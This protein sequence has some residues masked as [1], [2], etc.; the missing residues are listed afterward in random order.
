MAELPP[1]KLD[2]ARFE[3]HVETLPEAQWGPAGMDA[4]QF[5]VATNPGAAA[6][7]IDKIASGGELSRFMLAI[8]V[9]LAA[10]SSVPVLV[11]DEVDAGIG[12]ATADAVGERLARLAQSGRQ[13]LVV[14]HS[15][16]VAARAG[17][18]WIVAK[19][20]NDGSMRTTLMRLKDQ[21]NRTEE[22]AR[23]IS[24]AKV[25]PEALAAAGKL[26]QQAS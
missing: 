12:G 23:M 2:K 20:A 14:T 1:L 7:P 24:G 10:T 5:V 11:F 13:V 4:V 17:H 26:L 19:A 6:G 18:H 3:T 16:Q 9:V 25:T 22:I 21:K 15:P 8:K